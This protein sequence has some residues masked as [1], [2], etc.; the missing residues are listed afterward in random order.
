MSGA[1][2]QTNPKQTTTPDDRLWTDRY[3]AVITYENKFN[4][5]WLYT[6]KLWNGYQDS[7]HPLGSLQPGFG[8]LLG[9]TRRQR[10]HYTGL[11][12][13]FLRRW[14]RGNALTFGTPHTPPGAHTTSTST[15]PPGGSRRRIRQ[16]MPT[17]KTAALTMRPVFAENV[18]RSNTFIS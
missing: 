14:G 15:Q 3:T 5:S 10:F 1:Q 7:D 18:F 12:G 16:D 13:R 2:F 11:D 9:H 6:Q 8:R 4:E 17:P